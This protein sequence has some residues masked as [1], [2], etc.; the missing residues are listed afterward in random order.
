MCILWLPLLL[1][2]VLGWCYNTWKWSGNF[3]LCITCYI[4]TVLIPLLIR[5]FLWMVPLC[6]YNL[7]YCK[8]N[9][10]QCWCLFSGFV[11]HFWWKN[12]WV[13]SSHRLFY[14][15]AC[16]TKLQTSLTSTTSLPLMSLVS[17]MFV[18]LLRWTS[19]NMEIHRYSG[20]LVSP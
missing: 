19:R 9:S 4:V 18:H 13:L 3:V 5:F 10:L 6:H 20:V 1:T 14:V 16:A 2:V 15:S 7:I 12:C 17:E 8:H 11:R